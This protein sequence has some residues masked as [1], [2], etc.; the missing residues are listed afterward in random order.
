MAN[1]HLS[2]T[3]ALQSLFQWDFYGKPDDGLPTILQRN[4]VEFA[5]DFDDKDF[6]A[7]LL[8]QVVEHLPKI[9]ALITQYAPEWPLEQIT[10]VDRNVLRLGIYELKFD[11]DIPPKVAINEA[12]ELA[13]TFGGDSSG[14]FI[15]GVLG[16]I[17]KEMEKLGEK[18]G[19]DNPMGERQT[20]AGGVVFYQKD[21]QKYYALVLDA[22]ERWTFP[23]GKLATPDED[24]RSA[25]LR[26]I[27]EEI[28]L[29]DIVLYDKIGEIEVVVNEPNKKPAPKTIHLFLGETEKQEFTLTDK[30]EIKDAA[31]VAENKVMEQL[32]Y[33]Q[34]KEIFTQVIKMQQ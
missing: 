34:A 4:F 18:Q 11:L 6:S 22:H 25:A 27:S 5:P 32:G 14:K 15:N 30:P 26:E 29:K 12:I 33:D 16:S 19:M 7:F 13:K 20:S 21:N 1:R 10:L 3:L 2:R 8:Q 24:L 31:W 9:D 17:Y 23:K 28:G